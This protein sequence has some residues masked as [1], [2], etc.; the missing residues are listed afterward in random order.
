MN[1]PM[2]M[3]PREAATALGISR[4]TL[5]NWMAQGRI[6]TSR[7]GGRRLVPTQEVRRLAGVATCS[8]AA[9]HTLALVPPDETGE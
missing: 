2:C 3:K 9:V 7:V 6:A 8:A 5:C 4:A 1:E